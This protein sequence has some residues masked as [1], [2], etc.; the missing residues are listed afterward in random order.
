MYGGGTAALKAL[1]AVSIVAGFPLSIAICFMCASLHRACK[2][3]L[4][5][6]D[7]INSTR[8]IT[9]TALLPECFTWRPQGRAADTQFGAGLWDWTEGFAP[10]MPRLPNGKQLPDSAT[11]STSLALSILAPFLTLHDMNVKLWGAGAQ[12][13]ALTATAAVCFISVSSL[14]TPTT[15]RQY[16]CRSLSLSLSLS[17]SLSFLFFSLHQGCCPAVPTH[18][19]GG[20]SLLIPSSPFMTVTC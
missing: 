18:M 5:E 17:G 9:G 13:A 20:D 2:F 10:N 11:R 6:A 3:D 19:I 4:G 1:R 12:S 16:A 7:I 8:F 14:S 15:L